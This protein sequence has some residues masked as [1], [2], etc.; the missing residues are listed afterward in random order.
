MSYEPTRAVRHESIRL[1][2][3]QATGSYR[4][5]DTGYRSA[6]PSSSAKT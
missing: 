1:P 5:P 4:T 3:P 2:T 6:G